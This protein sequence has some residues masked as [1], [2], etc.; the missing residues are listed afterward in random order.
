M[1]LKNFADMP[2]RKRIGLIAIL[3]GIIAIFAG[4]PTSKARTTIDAKEIALLSDS[5]IME[6]HTDELADWI[7]KGKFDYRLIDLRNKG[8]FD[9]YNIPSSECLLVNQLLTSDLA[10]NE[11]ILLYGDSE[12]TSSQAWFLLKAAKYKSVSILKNGI[13]GWKK[14]VLFP[15]CTC[16]VN[17]TT[18]QKHNHAKLAEVS[19]FFGGGMQSGSVKPTGTKMAMPTLVAPA[20]ITLKKSRG[21]KK[22]EGC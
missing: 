3:L 21:K 13:E 11:K 9:K 6:V 14:Q 22:R 7:I 4:D 2:P 10:R 17:P 16:D 5:D 19:N 18:G 15:K 12:R 1:L 20:K 8:E